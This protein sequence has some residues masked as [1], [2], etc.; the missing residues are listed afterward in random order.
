MSISL[1]PKELTL[2]KV[3]GRYAQ[4]TTY[5]RYAVGFEPSASCRRTTTSNEQLQLRLL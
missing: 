5:Y 3:Y 1:K 2:I 4:N